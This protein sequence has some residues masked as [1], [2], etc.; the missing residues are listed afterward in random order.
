[1]HLKAPEF[2]VLAACYF[3][4]A[5]DTVSF[6]SSIFTPGGPAWGC[7]KLGLGAIAFAAFILR[8]R[9]PSYPTEAWGS[10]NKQRGLRRLSIIL[11][12][13]VIAFII[14]LIFLPNNF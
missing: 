3:L 9:L 14:S 2:V 1:M 12:V 6:I 4:V 11:A 5:L 8:A 10:E 7:V 13:F